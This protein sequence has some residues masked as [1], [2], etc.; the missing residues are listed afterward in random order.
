MSSLV[1]VNGLCKSYVKREVIRDFNIELMPGR[2]I[3][4]LGPNGSGKTTFIKLLAGILREDAGDIRI[5]GESIGIKSKKIVSYL[6]ERTYF[7]PSMKV[8]RL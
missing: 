6:P 5:G 3:G 7:S 8:G 2:I 1:S 4:L